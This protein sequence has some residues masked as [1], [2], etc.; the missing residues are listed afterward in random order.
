MEQWQS[1]CM[2]AVA[3]ETGLR[4]AE[5]MKVEINPEPASFKLIARYLEAVAD[6]RLS[7][8]LYRGHAD[9]RWQLMPSA[10]RAGNEGIITREHLQRWKI[11]AS[12]FASPKD[13]LGF[14]VLAQHY[15]I[16]TALLD[17]TTNPLTALYFACQPT[18]GD[19]RGQVLQVNMSEFKFLENTGATEIFKD[20]REKPALFDSSGMNVRTMAQDSFMSLHSGDGHQL[21]T[22]VVFNLSAEDKWSA[23]YALTALGLTPER[24]FADLGVAADEMRKW[25]TSA[26]WMLTPGITSPRH[27]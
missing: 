2:E 27:R 9:S 6:H 26:H 12:R 15:G 14:L 18:E 17:W 25:L 23:Q 4:Q 7:E 16:P 10:Y 19:T 5:V 11:M 13:E 21:A 22:T 3:L 24:V 8:T 20:N 1:H